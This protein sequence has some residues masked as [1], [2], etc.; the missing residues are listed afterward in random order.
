M[1]ASPHLP[2][3]AALALLGLVLTAVPGWAQSGL[4]VPRFVT[5]RSGE[6]NVRTGP[7][8]RYPV[9]WVFVRP[10]MP[11]EVV[12]EFDTWRK[13]RDHD[14]SEGWVHQSLLSGRRGLIVTGEEPRPVRAEPRAD[15]PLVARAEPGVIGRLRH[16]PA[17]AAWCEVQL[18]GY[19]GW[20]AR[21]DFWGAYPEE[22]VE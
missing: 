15:A 4:P 9:E 14:G 7:G 13:I 12:A 5:L 16:C 11:V 17:A 22:A 2:N 3:L 19:R 18:G 6:V 20:M 8:S 1:T 10:H 21:S